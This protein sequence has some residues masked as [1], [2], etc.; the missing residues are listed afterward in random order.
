[1]KKKKT[2]I[3]IKNDIEVVP[4]KNFILT[5]N[6]LYYLL[7]F[8]IILIFTQALRN[9]VSS[10]AFYSFIV[11]LPLN[12][13]ITLISSKGVRVSLEVTDST[14][15]KRTPFSFIIN[16]TNESIIPVPFSD[17]YLSIP[18]KEAVRT[19][20]KKVLISMPPSSQSS[21]NNTVS[22]PFRGS[23]EVGISAIYVYDFFKTMKFRVD[24]SEMK[25]LFVVPKRLKSDM[26]RSTVSSDASG[27]TSKSLFSPERTEVDDIRE[28]RI[29]DSLKSIHWKLSSK[30][31]NFIVRDYSQ[32]NVKAN[33]IFVD[34]GARDY[35]SICEPTDSAEERNPFVLKKDSYLYDMNEYCIDG[36]VECAVSVITRY[37]ADGEICIVSWNDARSASGVY[38]FKLECESDFEKIFKL[39]AGAPITPEHRGIKEL[40][41]VFRSFTDV[42]RTY[43]TASLDKDS[44]LAYTIIGEEDSS[45][46]FGNSDMI[47]FSSAE[48]MENPAAWRAYVEDCGMQLRKKG[49]TLKEFIPNDLHGKGGTA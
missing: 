30:S 34:L 9:P 33:L 7:A 24:I 23:Y 2:K 40:T 25:E 36:V 32:G 38:A 12:F 41:D 17:A 39:F 29:G 21:V 6:S 15:E 37:L 13:L 20:V 4:E 44:L 16:I 48:R 46:S 28:Y 27:L 5:K 26:M 22:F 47:Y 35:R 31:E 19:T 49:I 45:T 1:M 8:A 18:D 3:K 10:M 43:I 14:I 11:F 42:R